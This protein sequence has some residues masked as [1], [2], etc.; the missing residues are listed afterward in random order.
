MTRTK[1]RENEENTVAITIE[2]HGPAPQI[3]IEFQESTV[4]GQPER[5]EY[6][7]TGLDVHADGDVVTNESG[8][9]REATLYVYRRRRRK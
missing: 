2:F 9:A 8:S 7:R 3:R 1:T 5:P 6:S 4:Q